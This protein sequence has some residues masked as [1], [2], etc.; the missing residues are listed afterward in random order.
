MGD[1][2]GDPLASADRPYH[3]LDQPEQ[4]TGDALIAG[5]VIVKAASVPVTLPEQPEQSW[6][7]LLFQFIP[8]QGG[9]PAQVLLVLRDDQMAKTRPLLMGAIADARRAA[10]GGM[11]PPKIADHIEP[12]PGEAPSAD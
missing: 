8:A 10:A 5:G 4:A 2:A 11:P 6:P 9:P 12:P 7:A 3:R 1:Q